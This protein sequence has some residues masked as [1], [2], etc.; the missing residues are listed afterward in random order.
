VLDPAS[1]YT[2]ESGQPESGQLGTPTLVVALTGFVDAGHTGRLVA[3]HLREVGEAR[4]LARFDLDVMYDYRARRPTM[5]FVEDHWASFDA[6]TLDLLQLT[7]S[8]GAPFLLLT[9]PEPDTHWE[10]FVSAMIT[11]IERYDVATTVAVHGIPM[12]VPHTRPVSLT[13]H[14][15]RQELISG[16]RGWMGR[17]QVPGNVAGL[18]E[19]RLGQVG[20]DAIGYAVH[21]PH[22]LAQTEYP[23]AATTTLEQLGAVAGLTFSL[24]A[25][26]ARGRDVRASI[27]EQ[28]EGQPEVAAVVE[29]LESQYDAFL[30]A[31]GRSLLAGDSANLPTAE[32]LGAELERFLAEEHEK[33]TRGD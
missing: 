26:R 15:T 20:R 11:L 22:Y 9:G 2:L 16:H 13:A 4:L 27:D 17:L 12:A 8:L 14:A 23:D 6:P 31:S 7:D 10:R 29:G 1:L 18:L 28:V 21:V 30:G 24:D 32:E 19:L 5:E 33:R 25:L 3:E